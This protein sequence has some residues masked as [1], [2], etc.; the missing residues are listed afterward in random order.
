MRTGQPWSWQ[1]P[2]VEDMTLG[3]EGLVELGGGAVGQVDGVA[4]EPGDQIAKEMNLQ[5][6]VE[7]YN[8]NQK[9]K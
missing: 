1:V 8:K 4:S 5:E 6:I 9:N 7:K 2:A 3:S